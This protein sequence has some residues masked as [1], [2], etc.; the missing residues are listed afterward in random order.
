MHIDM[1]IETFT[2]PEVVLPRVWTVE[3]LFDT[4]ALTTQE[5]DEGTR[6][7]VRALT[8]G[9]ATGSMVAVGV[10][11]RGLDNLLLLVQSAVS[12]LKERGFRPFVVPA[13][14]SHGGAT[15][16]GQI[17]VLESYGITPASVGTEIRATMEVDLIARLEGAD[18]GD[19]AGHEVWCDRNARSA[20]AILLI[21][22]IKPHTDFTGP[23]ESGIAKMCAIGLGKRH[24][25]SGIHHYGAR[26][27]R[28]LMPR[29]ARSLRDHLPIVGGV[30]V[31]ENE[32]GRTS[33]VHALPAS[34]IAGDLESSLL[35]RARATSP[36]LPFTELDVL[37]VDEMGK[38]ISGAGMDT[39]VIGRGMMPSMREQDWGG[40][41]IR[42]IA[43]LDLTAAS[44]GNATAVGL[45]DLTTRKLIEKTDFTTMYINM[46]TSGEGGI[47]R[48]R[49]PL[50]MP[51][52]DDCVRTAMATCGRG[53]IADVRLARIRNTADTRFLEVSEALL[54]EARADAHL[55]VSDDDRPMDLCR[56]IA[57]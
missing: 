50:I 33:E 31:I 12:E 7:A 37:I 39:H 1:D 35:N 13:M 24:G 48:G 21:N 28:D 46:R 6:E 29:V 56:P 34:E 4:P 17:E 42:I 23:I 5:I 18:A 11:S 10:G 15:A 38:N 3:Q 41:N 14:G 2:Y 57:L 25:A 43:V 51:T 26:G 30:A 40:P 53:N 19:F 47:L 49:T 27:L 22:R 32:L 52:S 16:D 45:A 8:H 36:R 20:D 55:R 54:A 44:H 9:L